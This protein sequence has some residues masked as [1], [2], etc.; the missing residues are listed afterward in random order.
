MSK[1]LHDNDNAASGQCRRQDYSNTSVFSEKSR[2][3]KTQI[4]PKSQGHEW[5]M[6]GR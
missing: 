3:Y 4:K 1:F 5:D 2:A 6:L